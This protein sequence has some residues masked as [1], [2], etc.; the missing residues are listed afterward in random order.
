MFFTDEERV[1]AERAR[2]PADVGHGDHDLTSHAAGDEAG[3]AC[4]VCGC[5]GCLG[6]WEIVP[7]GG[8]L[9]WRRG[10]L[11]RVWRTRERSCVNQTGQ[12]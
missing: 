8:S 3:D 2:H 5:V 4:N 12:G 10:Y 7:P 6:W 9:A 11:A 1:A